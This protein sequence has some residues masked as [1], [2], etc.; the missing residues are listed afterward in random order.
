MIL[1]Y[2]FWWTL[3]TLHTILANTGITCVQ[4]YGVRVP[5][6][7]PRKMK[8]KGKGR[9]KCSGQKPPP[10]D[11]T[12][13]NSEPEEVFEIE[14]EEDNVQS[15][16]RATTPETPETPDSADKQDK[17]DTA[18]TKR[19]GRKKKGSNERLF[20]FTVDQEDDLIDSWKENE[21]LYNPQDPDHS[22]KGKKIR[23]YEERA[24]KYGCLVK[25]VERRMNSFRTDF[26][27]IL[28]IGPSGRGLDGQIDPEKLHIK[29]R[30]VWNRMSFL[31][32]YVKPKPTKSSAKVCIICIK[33]KQTA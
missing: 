8:G 27:R 17:Q 20:L 21:Y 24:K 22:D 3:I 25:D 13:E 7:P 1:S 6:M 31:K 12:T 19:L 10:K 9:G 29:D 11:S 16:S 33:K 18:P 4:F 26:G 2:I 5:K 32:D 28:H 30:I 15:D 14:A 23:W